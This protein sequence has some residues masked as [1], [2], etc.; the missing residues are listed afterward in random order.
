MPITH[1]SAPGDS[2]QI[3]YPSRTLSAISP[4]GAIT[5]NLQRSPLL[6]GPANGTW[7]DLPGRSASCCAPGDVVLRRIETFHFFANW[8]SIYCHSAGTGLSRRGTSRFALS[9]CIQI[10]SAIHACGPLLRLFHPC[11]WD[12]IYS[13][14]II[15]FAI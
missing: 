7:P 10:F 2:R 3:Y 14:Q 15:G 4:I 9:F 6:P 11:R 1:S 12:Y 13:I 8:T 5:C